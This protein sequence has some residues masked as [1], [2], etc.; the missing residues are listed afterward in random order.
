MTID[1]LTSELL[2]SNELFNSLTKTQMLLDSGTDQYKYAK[3]AVGI[4]MAQLDI[5]EA[6]NT[7]VIVEPT[8]NLLKAAVKEM[9]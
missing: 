2:S 3:Q 6:E 5:T 4:A 8:I 7:D 9:L 1:Q